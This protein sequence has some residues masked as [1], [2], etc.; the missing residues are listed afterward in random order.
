MGKKDFDLEALVG[1]P[2]KRRGRHPS[3]GLDC[4]GLAFWCAKGLGIECHEN[5]GHE[6]QWR[7]KMEF[8][9]RTVR[10]QR[11]D[12]LLFTQEV[13]REEDVTIHIG[14]CVDAQNFIHATSA[15]GQVTMERIVNYPFKR[16]WRPTL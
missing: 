6:F 14:V 3:E 5:P 2:Y 11:H 7:N 8:L 10:L 13:F 15:T 4:A 12:W 16:V 9:P 1:V